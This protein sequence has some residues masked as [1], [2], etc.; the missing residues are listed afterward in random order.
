MSFTSYALKMHLWC[1]KYCLRGPLTRH[2]Q[3]WCVSK[4]NRFSGCFKADWKFP[5]EK[6]S[7]YYKISLFSFTINMICCGAC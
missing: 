3:S 7:S 4:E 2:R 1:L 5:P 6:Q